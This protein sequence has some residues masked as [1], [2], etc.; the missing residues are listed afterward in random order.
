MTPGSNLNASF[1]RRSVAPPR[2][3]RFY[4][5]RRVQT[6]VSR[7]VF[8]RRNRFVQ[9]SAV[10]RR[11]L[12]SPNEIVQPASVL[13]SHRRLQSVERIFSQLAEIFDL[14]QFHHAFAG[15]S[16]E[17]LAKEKLGARPTTK[18][19]FLHFQNR[20]FVENVIDIGVR[21]DRLFSR[22]VESAAQFC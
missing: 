17:P 3:P 7:K 14:E 5:F 19:V 22:F 9:I 15:L 6:R 11:R 21:E 1:R 16:T 8:T 13:F 2:R 18:A 12:D 4:F 10:H 20:R